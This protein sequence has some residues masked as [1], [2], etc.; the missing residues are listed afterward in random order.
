MK[1][2]YTQR[3]LIDGASIDFP[4]QTMQEVQEAVN[5]FPY[6]STNK[7]EMAKNIMTV[8]KENNLQIDVAENN[9]FLKYVSKFQM[10]NINRKAPRPILINRIHGYIYD[11]FFDISLKTF[12][13]EEYK[14]KEM[15]Q[16]SFMLNNKSKYTE[17][18]VLNVWDTINNHYLGAVSEILI[19]ELPVDEDERNINLDEYELFRAIV[20]DIVHTGIHVCVH[21][22]HSSDLQLAHQQLNKLI[23]HLKSLIIWDKGYISIALI[24]LHLFS[25]RNGI[26]KDLSD[27]CMNYVQNQ[28]LLSSDIPD[29]NVMY[30]EPFLSDVSNTNL[31]MSFKS[32]EEFKKQME[33]ELYIINLNS[34]S[35]QG[36]LCILDIDHVSQDGLDSASFRL[37]DCHGKNIEL[38]RELNHNICT[39]RLASY[40]ACWRPAAK[41]H[42]L[43]IVG[44]LAAIVEGTSN[45]GSKVYFG[46]DNV[47]TLSIISVYDENPPSA[48]VLIPLLVNGERMEKTICNLCCKTVSSFDKS[49]KLT[50]RK[51]QFTNPIEKDGTKE[52]MINIIE[53]AIDIDSTGTVK[54]SLDRMTRPM[55]AYATLH[56]LLVE[57]DRQN[58]ASTMKQALANNFYLITLME[59]EMYKGKRK[60]KHTRASKEA[61]KTRMF[62]MNDFK[63]YMPKL[64][65][66]EQGFDFMTYYESLNFGTKELKIGPESI[67]GLKKLFLAIVH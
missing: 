26:F 11:G 44:K 6:V 46:I 66:L 56:K 43:G 14:K 4:L 1:E 3:H 49:D 17:Q 34:M 19:H 37:P 59:E 54:I 60:G 62:L 10:N 38:I 25:K 9:D 31:D 67:L 45:T 29:N 64:E 52:P 12:R 35:N 53:N 18:T 22:D 51:I 40:N 36:R 2:L 47:G 61:E 32:L 16:V 50:V 20:Q 39:D 58:N 28:Y 21:L 8:L 27:D 13:L 33:T 15:D 23:S 63:K 57:A 30:L 55:E 42:L 24:V 65:A 5:I 7:L 48:V 41:N